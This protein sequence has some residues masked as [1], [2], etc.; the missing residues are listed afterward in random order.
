MPESNCDGGSF[1]ARGLPG[2]DSDGEPCE[3]T[4][5][6]IDPISIKNSEFSV[7]SYRP[8]PDGS[9]YSFEVVFVGDGKANGTVTELYRYGVTCIATFE[10]IAHPNIIK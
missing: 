3:V 2:T 9:T 10:A 7:N 8:D 1:T 5:R 4:S 6:Y